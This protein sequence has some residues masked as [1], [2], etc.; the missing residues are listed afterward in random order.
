MTILLTLLLLGLTVG[1]MYALFAVSFGLI[2][3][4]THIFHF[5]HGAVISAGGYLVYVLVQ[6]LRLAGMARYRSGDSICGAPRRRDRVVLLSSAAAPQRAA[7]R[8]FPHLG[9]DSHGGRRAVRRDLRA[10]RALAQVSA[11]SRIHIGDVSVTTANLSML[12]AW[13]F[14]ALVVVVS[15]RDAVGPLHARGCRY[16]GGRQIDRHRSRRHVHLEFL[17]GFGTDGARDADVCLVS[18][19]HASAG[20]STILISS[21]A[22]IIGGRTGVLAGA[23]A[24]LGLGILQAV[25]IVF[26]PSGWQDAVVFSVLFFVIALRPN[27]VFGLAFRW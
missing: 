14:I 3:N 19:S 4:V 1:S 11:V 24:A 23:I 13:V 12:S 8:V 15:A 22:V 6:L 18:R 5:A 20:L 16:A 17:A 2:Y 9:R 10:G 21:A 26:L 25:A 7:R 27:G